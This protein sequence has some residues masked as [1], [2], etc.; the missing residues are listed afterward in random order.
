MYQSAYW[1][2]P[3]TLR[4]S[5]THEVKGAIPNGRTRLA[6]AADLQ[7]I[8]T[9]HTHCPD[10]ALEKG[11]CV[12]VATGLDGHRPHSAAVRQRG[13]GAWDLKDGR[14]LQIQGDLEVPL[15]RMRPAPNSAFA[16]PSGGFARATRETVAPGK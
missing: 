3:S 7:N 2:P 16:P 15:Q 1:D 5:R 8:E 4:V 9:E 6:N 13:H 12:V 10:G 11:V 14:P